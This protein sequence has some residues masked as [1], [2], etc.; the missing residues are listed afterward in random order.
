MNF[1]TSFSLSVQTFKLASALLI[2]FALVGCASVSLP[3]PTATASTVEKLRA[4]KLSPAAVGKF[5]L[6]AGKKPEMDQVLSGL[7]GS[8][9]AASSGSFSQ[10]LKDELLTELKAAGLYDA[11]SKVVIEA[12][13]T[14]S[15]VDAGISKGTGRLAA[16][17]TV[18]KA[19]QRA[20]D[21]ELAVD[22]TWES[23][24]IGAIALPAAINQYSSFYKS[25][26]AK[27]FD[28]PEFRRAL[29]L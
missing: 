29:A 25:L 7:R 20:F 28:D 5:S 15:A 13:L 4:A 18:D 10:Y 14:D 12:Q 6:A 9:V 17:F 11:Q 26:I 3:E 21:K 22:A 2:G 27:L 8:S 24:F 1:Q 23:S 19:G 16:R